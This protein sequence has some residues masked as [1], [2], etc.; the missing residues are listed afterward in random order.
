[1]DKEINQ[2]KV[3]VVIAGPTAVGK[4]SLSIELAQHFKSPILSADS[5]QLYKEM[6]IGTA[7]PSKEEMQ[8]VPHYF[9]HSHSIHENY[10][11]GKYEEEV[12]NTLKQLFLKHN[13]VFLVGGSGLYIK[14]VCEGLDELPEANGAIREELNQAYLNFGLEELLKELKEK[15]PSYFEVVDKHNPQRIIRALEVIRATQKPFSSF[16]SS[17]NKS[18]PFSIIKIGI[19]ENREILYQKIDLRMDIMLDSGLLNEAKNLYPFKSH[20]ALRTV[21]YE[22]IFDY[23]EEKKSWEE[24]VFLLKRNS[25]RYAKRQLTWFRKDKAFLWFHASSINEIIE[26]ISKQYQQL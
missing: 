1:M 25:R 10:S 8:D 19:E 13:L 7:K 21:G 20:N 22:E 2:K 6:N 3:L 4:T 17:T 9:I 23:L 14:A 18:R 11:V 26:H 24:T 5:R 12:L 15:D 16:L